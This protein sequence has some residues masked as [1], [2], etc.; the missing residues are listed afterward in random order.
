[1]IAPI[2]LPIA[3]LARR[4]RC[5]RPFLIV[6]ES[7]VHCM[8]CGRLSTIRLRAAADPTTGSGSCFL[9]ELEHG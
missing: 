7:G 9:R 8:K 5:E 1:M 4:C 2:E 3:E 6:D